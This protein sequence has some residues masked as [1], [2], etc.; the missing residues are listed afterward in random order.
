LGGKG[1]L[2]RKVTTL[3][4]QRIGR[5]RGREGEGE[6]APT[7]FSVIRVLYQKEYV[8]LEN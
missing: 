8:F 4:N 6:K 5:D 7:N 3:Q 1:S 2:P